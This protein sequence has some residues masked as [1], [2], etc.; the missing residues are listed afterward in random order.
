MLCIAKYGGGAKLTDLEKALADIDA[1]KSQLARG[2]E[3]RGYGPATV[4][5][6]GVLAVVA[7]VVQAAWLG[8]P[9]A[10]PGAFVAIWFTTAALGAALIGAEAVTRSRRLHSALAD[11]M[12]YAAMA[13]FL[14]A[15]VAGGLLTFVLFRFAPETLWMLPGLW[16]L[17]FSLGVFA[18]CSLLPKPV[19]VAGVWYLACGLLCLAIGAGELALSPWVMGAPFGLGQ[20]IFAGIL[21]RTLGESDAQ[22]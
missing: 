2:A 13:Q 1:I 18:S 9:T 14:P 12:V 11:E 4:A 16:Q 10:Q 17:L 21:Q 3:F 5:L 7:A 15:S 22:V 20:L 8:N 19:F 6:T